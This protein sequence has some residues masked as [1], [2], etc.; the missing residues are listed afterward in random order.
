MIV[1]QQPAR[2]RD[3]WTSNYFG[4]GI[5]GSGVAITKSRLQNAR[6][7][8]A[9][10]HA[11]VSAREFL[12]PP[13]PD[14]MAAELLAVLRDRVTSLEQLEA[15]LRLRGETHDRWSAADLATRLGLPIHAVEEA[16]A[17]L[18]TQGLVHEL[19]DDGQR[20]WCYRADAVDDAVVLRLAE[21]YRARPLEVMRL[22]SAQALDRIR[23]SAARAFA[24][25]FVIG[26]KKD[27]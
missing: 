27:G 4:A 3:S 24:D 2:R 12:M 26:R 10:R 14:E 11:D 18:A 25:A 6:E 20:R 15:L 9:T 8:E 17:A 22:L 19:D 13:M 21:Y 1:V 5:L 7:L 23:N 16:L